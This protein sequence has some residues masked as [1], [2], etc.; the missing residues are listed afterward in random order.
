MTTVVNWWFPPTHHDRH[1][2]PPLPADSRPDRPLAILRANWSKDGDFLAVDHRSPGTTTLT[3]LYGSGRPWIGPSWS[4]SGPLPAE[5]P[6]RAKPTLWVSQ[7]SAD[8]AEWSFKVGRARVVRTAV[9]MRGRKIALL[10]EQWDG[11]NDPG[12]TRWSLAE[13]VDVT[14]SEE[15]R[16]LALSQAR[17]KLSPRA[18][19]IALPRLPY[20]T[21]RGGLAH[22]G[23]GLVLRQVPTGRR[24]WRPLL[25]SWDPKRDRKALQWR[26]LTVSEDSKAC[27]PDVA[28]A[29][30]VTWGRDETLLI[31]RSLAAPATRAFL[32]HQTRARFLIGIFTKE[33]EVEPLL[34]VAD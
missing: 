4:S 20:A 6:T 32:G 29:A 19:P 1:A 5:P 8:A 28:F 15:N 26:A 23:G 24:S 14:K 31:Y 27:A 11:P 30:R 3:E 13:G 17:T 7:S 16:G 21:D 2:P 22:E 10:A 33:G 34:T 18:L 25:V 12:G 9:L